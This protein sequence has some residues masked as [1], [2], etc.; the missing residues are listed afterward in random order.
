MIKRITITVILL[1]IGYVFSQ[2]DISVSDTNFVE[3]QTPDTAA[4]D[5]SVDTVLEKPKKISWYFSVSPR[6]GA[7]KIQKEYSDFLKGREDSLFSSVRKIEEFRFARQDFL[8]PAVASGVLF[9]IE[10]GICANLNSKTSIEVG[11]GYSFNRMRYIYKIEHGEDSVQVL[12]AVSRLSKNEILFSANYK[13]G[14]DSSYFS[15]KGVDKA[16]FVGA[17]AFV[18]SRYSEYD[19]IY[20]EKLPQFSQERRGK[21][22][23]FG[24][25]VKAGLFAQKNIAKNSIF[26]YSIGYVFAATNG[27]NGFWN[28]KFYGNNSKNNGEILVISNLFILSFSLII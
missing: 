27:Y 14:F 9:Y 22:D 5:T 28:R 6:V 21:Y 24:G 19:T 12:K 18:L 16:G 1:F 4:A 23:G 26:E 15:I 17:A 10:T 13:I 20:C 25:S 11:G 3:V 8:Q 2:D 7:D